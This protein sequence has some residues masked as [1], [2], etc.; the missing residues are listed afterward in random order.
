MKMVMKP[1]LK[2][3]N[4][5]LSSK[6]NTSMSNRSTSKQ[7]EAEISQNY[8]INQINFNEYKDRTRNRRQG[9]HGLRRSTHSK[10]HTLVSGSPRRNSS[11][12]A[13]SDLKQ[14]NSNLRNISSSLMAGGFSSP[15]ETGILNSGVQFPKNGR[16]TVGLMN[17]GSPSIPRKSPN[18]F[19]KRATATNPIV[20]W[21]K[22]QTPN[23]VVHSYVQNNKNK[24][25]NLK[26][27]LKEKDSSKKIDL[28]RMCEFAGK[29]AGGDSWN[30]QFTFTGQMPSKRL[31]LMKGASSS[32]MTKLLMQFRDSKKA[33]KASL[34]SSYKRHS[35]LGHGSSKNVVCQ[36]NSILSQKSTTTKGKLKGHSKNRS[37]E[38]ISGKKTFKSQFKEKSGSLHRRKR[39]KIT[40]SLRTRTGKSGSNSEKVNQD[41]FITRPNFLN[42][43]DCFLFGVFDGHGENGH[44][45]SNFI[46]N[47]LAEQVKSS[48]EK[49]RT[50]SLGQCL[51]SGYSMIFNLLLKSKIETSFSGSTA[52]TCLLDKDVLFTANSGDSRAI[53]GYINH[54]NQ[55]THQPLSKDHKPE[56]EE[57]AK[58]IHASGGRIEPYR[59]A[60]GQTYGPHRIWLSNDDVPGLAMSRAFGDLVACS[61]GV[62]WKPDI[63]QYKLN[64]SDKFI[65]IGSDG[66]FEHLSNK[67]LASIVWTHYPKNDIEAACDEIMQKAIDGWQAHNNTDIDDITFILIF[68][69]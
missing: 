35:S 52:V 29:M 24:N 22:D 5:T 6:P 40:Y 50:Q 61:V 58:R 7:G 2:M 21:F 66:V 44:L 59:Q 45:V 43:E 1:S 64:T 30:R 13:S 65:L 16:N 8:F 38:L 37:M 18:I 9:M 28:K 53:I 36:E 67:Q 32:K 31:S 11:S 69:H 42:R 23:S 4:T 10:K 26:I 14:T 20:G 51:F 25:L 47:N 62:T 56:I 48:V 19:S 68:I 60:N 34:R 27:K 57:E 12:K 15:N 54:D 17:F 55:I 49:Q 33:A 46:S 41:S 63:T 39:L 3:K